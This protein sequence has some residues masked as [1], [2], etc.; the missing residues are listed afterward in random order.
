[1][2][3]FYLSI[4]IFILTHN[5]NMSW[6]YWG[7]GDGLASSLSSPYPANVFQIHWQ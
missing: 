4:I 1:M 6:I 3:R 7:W 5:D 2:H